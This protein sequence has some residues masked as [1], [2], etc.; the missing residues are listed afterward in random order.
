MLDPEFRQPQRQ[1]IWG[2]ILIFAEFVFKFGKAFWPFLIFIFISSSMQTRLYGMLGLPILAGLGVVYSY[3]Y[4]RNFLF[5][6]D[7][8]NEK[9]AL[10]KGVFSS[11]SIR[12]PFD[13]IQQVDLK[14]SIL[15]RF[16]GVYGLTIDTAGSKKDEILIH[17]MTKADALRISEILTRL[18]NDTVSNCSDENEVLSEER[19]SQEIPEKTYRID[20]WTLIKVGLT[21][22]YLRGFALIF[23]FITSLYNQI[24]G[25]FDEYL[26]SESE[27]DHLYKDLSTSVLMV[28]GLI[29]FTFILSILVTIGEVIIRHWDLN[30]RQTAH[31]IQIEMGL[32]TNTKVSFQARRLQLLKILTNPIQK[33]LNLYEAHFFLAS[34]QND[35][36]KSKIIA[37]GLGTEIIDQLKAFLYPST[38]NDSSRKARPHSA[39]INRRLIVIGLLLAGLWSFNYLTN[40][41]ENPVLLGSVTLLALG[42][43][44]PYQYF[45]YRSIQLDVSDDFLFIKQGLW[46]QKLEIL[47]LY[48]MEGVSIK[49]PFWY[50]RRKL[51]NL[52]FHTA[53]GDLQM[54][55]MPEKFLS[56]INYLLFK[57]ESSPQA[58]M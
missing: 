37:P 53:G 26:P 8:E 3:F 30:I 15:Q 23:V 28:A 13:K 5:Y 18:K 27:Y 43:L 4:Y 42:I 21:R 9:F 52:T 46:T 48:K 57:A 19:V 36:E 10:D 6:I 25:S 32:K 47:E 1:A 24:Q 55:A 58:W 20:L 38:L 7:Y 45:L 14:R 2:I 12:I 11:K 44:V 51:Y 54:R 34:S 40:G 49:Q 29:V 17:A 33:K 16:I 35:L 39:W 31:Q 56:E 41:L 50:K 22:S